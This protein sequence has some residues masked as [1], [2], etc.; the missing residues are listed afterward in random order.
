MVGC[1][2]MGMGMGMGTRSSC[3]GASTSREGLARPSRRVT[4][5]RVG[6]VRA[7]CE[8]AQ[9]GGQA[10][11]KAKMGGDSLLGVSRLFAPG[12]DFLY[13]FEKHK[14]LAVSCPAEGGFEGRFYSRMRRDGWYYVAMSARG[15][16]DLEAYLTRMHAMRPPHLGKRGVEREFT[17]PI[18][19][20]YLGSRPKGTKGL[21]LVI[22]E[23]KVLSRSELNYLSFL[24][25]LFARAGS[26]L[27]IAVEVGTERVFA[28]EPLVD[29][30]N[31]P[32]E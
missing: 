25:E 30:V 4:T 2:A 7:V 27:R 18:I 6:R 29:A 3:C 13:D 23:G 20:M 11:A 15:L 31:A 28:W 16:G 26:Q 19:Q 22:Q 17:P 8:A 14:A 24:P 32:L 5:R 1:G 21:L 12:G 9:G 10:K